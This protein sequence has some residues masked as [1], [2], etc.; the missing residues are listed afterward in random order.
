MTKEIKKTEYKVKEKIASAFDQ[1]KS[2]FKY[3]NKLQAPRLTKITISVATGRAMKNDK[4]KNE[5]V[6]DRLTKI[7]GQK[8]VETEAKKAIASFKTRTDER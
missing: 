2:E 5:F 4:K 6:I 7:V 8:A 3:K 1:M